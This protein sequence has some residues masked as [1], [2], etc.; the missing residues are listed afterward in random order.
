MGVMD[1]CGI[2]GMAGIFVL[3]I[4]AALLPE[5]SVF[6]GGGEEPSPIVLMC[7]V[8]KDTPDKEYFA[9]KNAG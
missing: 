3:V 5:S 2:R 7:G 8:E 1:C 6:L 9:L 4:F